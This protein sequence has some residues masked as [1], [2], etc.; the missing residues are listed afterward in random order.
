ML[1]HLNVTLPSLQFSGHETFPLRQLWLRKAYDNLRQAGAEAPKSTFTDEQAIV[2]FGVGK[3]MATS[4][5]HWALACDFMWE[6][7][8]GNYAPTA[9]AESLFG[10]GGLDPFFEHPAS[11]WMIHWKLAG[12][13]TKSTTWW[14]LFNCVVQQSFDKEVLFRGITDYCSNAKYKVSENTLRRD[15]DVCIASYM[16]RTTSSTY[17]DVAEPVLSELPLL[18]EHIGSRAVFSFV[19]GPKAS[20][21]DGMF[22][23]ALVEFW[24]CHPQ[25]SVLSFEKIA[26]EYGSP[27]RVFKLDEYSIGERVVRM[28]D[29]TKGALRW[30]DSAGIRQINRAASVDVNKLK[31]RL[32]EAA[33]G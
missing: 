25:T 32:L 22:C 26:H 4:I 20:L 14:W 30:T 7:G 15:I 13:G 17:E 19:R 2:R 21:P 31:L 5:R 1:S 3:N 29:L 10:D 12:M 9:L 27:G 11:A 6:T 16:P 18:Q 24:N 28:E 23:Y 8:R 33:Y